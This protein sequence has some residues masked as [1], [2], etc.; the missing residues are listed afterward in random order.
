[1]KYLSLLSLSLFTIVMT[2]SCGKRNK[3]N[4]KN[5]FFIQGKSYYTQGQYEQAENAFLNCLRVSPDSIQAHRC[6]G[7]IYEN[8]N[9]NYLKAW[10]HY[11]AFL[12]NAP[13]DDKSLMA[14][15]KWQIEVEKK[16]IIELLKNYPELAPKPVEVE[17]EV[18]ANSANTIEED[19]Q[20][21]VANSAESDKRIKLLTK[22]LQQMAIK[23]EELKRNIQN[24][25]DDV[26]PNISEE[27]QTERL[28]LRTTTY[29]IKAGDGLLI[30]SRRFYGTDKHWK[31]IRDYNYEV[32]HGK[33]NLTKG[34]QL[35]IPHKDDLNQA[36]QTVIKLELFRSV[37]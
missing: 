26:M 19:D 4:D 31:L 16:L 29:T 10:Y 14:V 12:D 13:K 15:A 3:L 32:L 2:T 28:A 24:N 8:R 36:K 7:M 21:E 27:P 33:D 30:L 35:Q 1:M 5:P 17:V 18:V 34:M 37:Q 6:L 22:R 20:Q 23:V 9:K 25:S 11:R